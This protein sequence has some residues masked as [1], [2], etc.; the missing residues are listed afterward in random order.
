MKKLGIISGMGAA[1]GVRFYDSLIR[2][3][4]RKGAVNDSD[5]PEIV[6][7]NISETGMNATG[8]TDGEQTLHAL[9]ASVAMLNN[10]GCET[11]LIA[12]NTAHIYLDTLQK[13]STAKIKNMIHLAAKVCQPHTKVGVISS[14]CTRKTRLYD[15][16][17]HSHGIE[18]IRTTHKQQDLVDDVIAKVIAGKAGFS[19]QCAILG[20]VQMMVRNGAERVILGCTEL[21]LV[22]ELPS[23]CVDAG[24]VMIAKVVGKS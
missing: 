16:A 10:Y 3:Y 5:F 15:H 24:A 6:L 13:D 1:A 17:L 19:E 2:A 20:I 22:G 18:V 12:C 11:I 8:V 7:H 14:A 4:Q 23:I 9:Q 21:P